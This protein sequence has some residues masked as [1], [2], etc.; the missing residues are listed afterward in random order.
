VDDTRYLMERRL[1]TGRATNELVI[2]TLRG[3]EEL[4]IRTTSGPTPF[5]YRY[6]FTARE[7][8]TIVRLSAEVSLG[9]AASLLG[10]LA[11]G[12]VKRGV[13]ANFATLRDILEQR[14]GVASPTV[15]AET[16]RTLG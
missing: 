5:T 7:P 4:V 1:P 13:D 3:P 11:A 12:A 2:A 16:A 9:G 15:S 8:S 6:E 14:K 10:P